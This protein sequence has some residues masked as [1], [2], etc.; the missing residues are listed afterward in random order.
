MGKKEKL[1]KE[2]DFLKEEFR[3]YFLILVALFSGES[4][5]VYAVVSGEK[6]VYVLLLAVIGLVLLSL[7]FA[8]ISNIKQIIYNKLDK[9][10]EL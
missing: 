5:L 1:E 7:L 2:I 6:P 4:G 3:G 10:E 9:L 8:K